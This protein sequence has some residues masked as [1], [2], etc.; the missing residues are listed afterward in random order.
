MPQVI[1]LIYASVATQ[2]MGTAE[3]TDLLQKARLANETLGLTGMLLHSDRNFFQ[4]LEGESAV[5]DKLYEKIIRDHRHEQCTLIIRE[6]IARRSFGDW[7]MGFSHVS[8]E[9]LGRIEGL[10]DFFHTGSCLTQ[11]D[12]GRAKKIL[13]AFAGGSWRAKRAKAAG[14]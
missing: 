11:L 8:P 5:V 2:D 12:A 10:N 14:V 9:E 1:H 3:L 6:P 4:V 7:S 13:A